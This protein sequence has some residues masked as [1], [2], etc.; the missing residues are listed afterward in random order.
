MVSFFDIIFLMKNPLKI[1]RIA[2]FILGLLFIVLPVP[3]DM[4]RDR[5]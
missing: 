2:R 4:S 1:N 5:L 3:G